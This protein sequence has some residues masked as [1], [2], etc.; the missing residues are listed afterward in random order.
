MIS[1]FLHNFLGI[2]QH[3][4]KT[5]NKPTPVVKIYL[6]CETLYFAV[7]YV[8]EVLADYNVPQNSGRFLIPGREGNQQLQCQ[9][10]IK[11]HIKTDE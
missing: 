4:H 10:D 5:L 9:R 11:L 3:E 6:I 2:L 8:S 7:Y 1:M